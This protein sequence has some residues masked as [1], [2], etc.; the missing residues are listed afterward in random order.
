MLE[1]AL[2]LPAHVQT[3][4]SEQPQVFDP[5]A[6]LDRL[7]GDREL[8]SMLVEVYRQDC[9]QLLSDLS[10]GLE[11]GNLSEVVRAAHSLKGLAANFEA[12]EASQ[13]A[14]TVEKMAHAGD[15]SGAARGVPQ[16][17]LH[18]SEL[19]TALERWEQ[20]GS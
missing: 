7:D 12:I 14:A 6:M 8:A 17:Q 2:E 20:A 11:T 5:Q 13:V 19:R 15:M 16:L 10:A 9:T 1:D 3:A 18:L 4:R